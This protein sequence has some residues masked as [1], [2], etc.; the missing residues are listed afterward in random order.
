MTTVAA[1]DTSAFTFT[2]LSTVAVAVGPAESALVTVTRGPDTAYQQLV[3][4]TRDIGPFL[5]DDEMTVTSHLGDITYTVEAFLLAGTGPL[6]FVDLND[7]TASYAGNGGKVPVVNDAEDGLE[8]A[9]PVE[10]IPIPAD[11]EVGGVNITSAVGYVNITAL[12]GMTI[13]G[14]SNPMD[15]GLDISGAGIDITATGGMALESGSGHTLEITGGG[16]VSIM[17]E[18]SGDLLLD[19]ANDLQINT[20]VSGEIVVNGDTGHTGPV[21]IAGLVSLTFTNGILT[22]TA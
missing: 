8:L 20:G 5:E 18:N 6:G 13:A 7:V 15:A 10:G 9:A 4:S 3:N 17:A 11:N 14:S 1:G 16:G 22:G 21:T 2:E 12:T 19:S